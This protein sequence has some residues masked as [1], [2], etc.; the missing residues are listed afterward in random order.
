MGKCIISI[1]VV[2]KKEAFADDV[3]HR[4][5]I[6]NVTNWQDYQYVN[7]EDEQKSVNNIPRRDGIS[8]NILA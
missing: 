3:L 8:I 7:N 1:T 2:L 5:S 4:Y 6:S